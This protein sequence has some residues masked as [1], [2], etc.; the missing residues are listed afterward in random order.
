MDIFGF[1]AGQTFSGDHYRYRRFGNEVVGERSQQ[2]AV[3]GRSIM[4]L[5][6]RNKKADSLPFQSTSASGAQDN[7]RR[8]EAVDLNHT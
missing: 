3:D 8:L 5:L 2:N 4:C 1:A 6:Q 7:Q